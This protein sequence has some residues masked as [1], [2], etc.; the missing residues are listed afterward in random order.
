ME[1]LNIDPKKAAARHQFWDTQPV[2]KLRKSSQRPTAQLARCVPVYDLPCYD[3]RQPLCDVLRSVGALLSAAAI[4]RRRSDGADDAEALLDP[5]KLK[6]GP[7]DDP[8]TVADVR[9]E[10][11]NLPNG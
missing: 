2:P 7:I 6:T 1:V 9:Q 8:K 10:P 3:T 11:Y 4:E 5:S